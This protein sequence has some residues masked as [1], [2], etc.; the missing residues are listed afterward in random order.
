MSDPRNAYTASPSD[1]RAMADAMDGITVLSR[2]VKAN[3]VATSVPVEGIAGKDDAFAKQA[4]PPLKDQDAM[5]INVLDALF[6]ALDANTRAT[7]GNA[8]E[9]ESTQNANL[10][11]IGQLT[12]QTAAGITTGKH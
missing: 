10:D 3:H 1:I 6:E 9:I 7:L 11:S 4:G 2:S 8:G 5:T 12:A